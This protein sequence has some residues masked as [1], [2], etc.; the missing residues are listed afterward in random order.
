MSMRHLFAD[1][2]PVTV[3]FRP[4]QGGAAVVTRSTVEHFGKTGIRITIPAGVPPGEYDILVERDG[5]PVEALGRTSVASTA[6][7]EIVYP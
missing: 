2:E 6:A 7:H 5:K 1:G 3:V 4:A